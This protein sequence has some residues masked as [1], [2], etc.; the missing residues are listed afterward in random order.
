[1]RVLFLPVLSLG[2][3]SAACSKAPRQSD[4]Q[5]IAQV[6]AIQNERAPAREVAPEPILYP[7]IMQGKLIAAGCNFVADGGGM[8]AI[9]MA[10][11]DRGVI[12]LGGHLV[13]LA[14]DKGSARMPLGS[15][16]HYVGRDYALTFTRIEGAS[17]SASASAGT[18]F[19]GSVQ[20][21]TFRAQVVIS[22][23]DA[24]AVYAAKGEAQCKSS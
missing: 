21:Q 17:A 15:W 7:D 3:L 19:G 12:K 10:Q 24:R 23:A 22:D 13:A 14:A 16:S 18:P 4:E 11:A 9:L 6:E 20:A 2:L 5:A 1:M 8:G